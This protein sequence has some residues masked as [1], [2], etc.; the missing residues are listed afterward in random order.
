M[1][2][3]KRVL[4]TGATGFIGSNLLRFFL[5]Q[6][7]IVFIFARATSSK[8]RITGEL[9][10]VR[11]FSVDLTDSRRV[12]RVVTRIKPSFIIHTAA[13]GGLFFQ[14]DLN[15]IIRTNFLGTVNLL[16]ACKEAGFELF[17][18]TGSSSEYGPKSVHMKETDLPEPIDGYGLSKCYSTMYCRALAIK[19][20]LPIVTLRLFSPY[21]YYENQMRLTAYVIYSALQGL[22]PRLSSKDS[23]RDYVFIEDVLRAYELVI[24][25]R[26]RIKGEVINIGSGRQ[27]TVGEVVEEIVRQMHVRIK[28]LWHRRENPKPEPESWQADISKAKRLLG[29]KPEYGLREGLEKYI[30]WFKSNI[31]LYRT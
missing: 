30:D 3:N 14:T 6:G 7:A 15:K 4:I 10:K 31:H 22:N 11:K 20:N 9:G 13:Y 24:E 18:N 27:H 21:G 16:N 23:V 8:W 19:E 25:N 5:S 1:L 17:V 2:K 29:W 26:K 28:P 12:R